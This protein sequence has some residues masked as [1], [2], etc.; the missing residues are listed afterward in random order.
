MRQESV[1]RRVQEPYGD[2]PVLHY[3][4]YTLKIVFLIRLQ[5]SYRPVSFRRILSYYHSYKIIYSIL[6]EKHMLAAAKAHAFCP[7]LYSQGG[8]FRSIYICSHTYRPEFISPFEYGVEIVDSLYVDGI[9]VFK[10]FKHQFIYIRRPYIGYR[11]LSVYYAF[12]YHIHGDLHR[13]SR[14]PSGCFSLKHIEFAALYSKFYL[15]YIF[16][17]S[18]QQLSDIKEFSVKLREEIFHLLYLHSF[19]ISERS[20]AALTLHQKFSAGDLLSRIG[21]SR[22]DSTGT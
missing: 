10:L 5:G 15:L 9:L 6:S 17:I 14:S 4:E 18:F 19:Y 7:Q 13:C 3:P 21:I 22:K 2:G 1:K 12:A 8:V 11:S 20:I 16:I